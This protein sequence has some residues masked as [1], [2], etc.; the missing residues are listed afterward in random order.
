VGLLDYYRQ[1][2]GM[3]EEEVNEGLRAQAAERRRKALARVETLDLS[4]TTWPDLPHPRIVNTIAFVALSGLH[5]YPH[6]TGSDLRNE[7]A[8]RHDVDP[9]RLILGNGAAE[10]LSSATR[11]LIAPGQQ[12]LTS[13]PSYPLFPIMARRAHGRAAPVTGGVDALLAAAREADTRVVALASPNDPTGELLATAELERLLDGLPDGVAVLL[14]ESLVEFADAQ[15][16]NSSLGL[17]ENHSRLLVF[18]SFSK[19]WGLAGLRVGYAIGGP[20]SEDLL[21]ELEPDLGVSEVSQAGALEALRS[22]S[23][24]LVSRVREISQERVRLTAAL[25]ERKFEVTDSQANFVWASHPSVQGDELA[26]LLERA[27]VLVAAGAALGEPR[28]VRI[29]LRD[30]AASDRLLETI[31]KALT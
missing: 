22:C 13:W 26:A 17:L 31:D 10:L 5:R 15:P 27:G 9:A 1:F 19:A 24:L 2:E 16:T 21:A 25:R 29:G 18:R 28:H 11:A 3:S 20:G 7:L 8:E 4:Q 6:M 23:D 12:L 30:S 14:D